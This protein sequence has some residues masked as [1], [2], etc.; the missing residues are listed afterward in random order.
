MPCETRTAFLENKKS[1][2]ILSII[3]RCTG[4]VHEPCSG[5]SS[6][7]WEKVTTDDN[8]EWTCQMC[9]NWME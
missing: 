6:D 4:W 8:T 1:L 9:E 7:K 3:R 2:L 5:L